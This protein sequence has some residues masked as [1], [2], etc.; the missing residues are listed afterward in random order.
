MMFCQLLNY[1][2]F[3]SNYISPIFWLLFSPLGSL[4]SMLSYMQS[5]CRVK[6][7]AICGSVL[8]QIRYDMSWSPS[9]RDNWVWTPTHACHFPQPGLLPTSPFLLVFHLTSW[10]HQPSTSTSSISY[11]DLEHVFPAATTVV[12]NSWW[13]QEQVREEPEMLWVI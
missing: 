9:K 4:I 12:N 11:S 13:T 6:L 10:P 2:L 5:V 8:L 1:P 7:V 3:I